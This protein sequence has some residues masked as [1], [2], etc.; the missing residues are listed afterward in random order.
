M[1]NPNWKPN[2]LSE[3]EQKIKNNSKKKP[4]TKN[5]PIKKK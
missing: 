4:D 1:A 2:K 5:Q 3:S